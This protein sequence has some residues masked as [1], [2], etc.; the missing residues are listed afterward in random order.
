MNPRLTTVAVAALALGG[1][2]AYGLMGSARQPA[3]AT[4]SGKAL[5]GGPFS[6]ID[7]TGKPVTDKDF[8]GRYML[9]F[10]GYTYCPD[11]CPASLQV[12][13][14]ALDQLDPDATTIT[15]LLDAVPGALQRAEQ[16]RTDLAAR[17]VVPLDEL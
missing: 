1:A 6:L 14:A 12:I 8:R 11:V 16:G 4:V 2:V 5:I 9:V 15:A 3:V 7:H 13:S 10:F 17:R